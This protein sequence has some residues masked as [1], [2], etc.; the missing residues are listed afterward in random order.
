MEEKTILQTDEKAGQ[1]EGKEEYP[2]SQILHE[3]LNIGEQMLICGGEVSR[4]EDT[5]SRICRAYEM[6]K[7]DERRAFPP[8]E[9]PGYSARCDRRLQ[10]HLHPAA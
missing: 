2:A 8:T 10:V 4:V 3:A 9:T 5:I 6:K 7:V 1:Q